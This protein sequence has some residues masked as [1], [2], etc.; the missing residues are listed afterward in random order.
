MRLFLGDLYIAQ[1]TEVISMKEGIRHSQ[2][3]SGNYFLNQM[4]LL[5]WVTVFLKEF[6]YRDS[7]FGGRYL[8]VKLY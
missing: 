4:K 3:T 6:D 7:G 2:V 8:S 1:S 5:E